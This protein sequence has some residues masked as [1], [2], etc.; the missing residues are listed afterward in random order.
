MKEK[1]KHRNRKNIIE[2]KI[3]IINFMLKTD[4]NELTTHSFEKALCS[5]HLTI[6]PHLNWWSEQTVIIPIKVEDKI[7]GWKLNTDMLGLLLAT[8]IGEEL[9]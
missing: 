4:K 9:K 6:K 8:N 1:L 2:M 7:V 5:N 3:G